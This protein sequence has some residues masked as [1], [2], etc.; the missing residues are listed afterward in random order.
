MPTT[1]NDIAEMMGIGNYFAFNKTL[2]KNIGLEEAI[3][4]GDL[5][6]RYSYY[7]NKG[8]LEND[9]FY[10][11]VETLKEDTTLS[12]YQQRKCFNNLKS[13]GLIDTH[14]KGLPAK[15]YIELHS[16]AILDMLRRG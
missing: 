12:D 15:R 2:A 7:F 3:I 1:I 6:N 13:L 14:I 8:L 11:T 16:D 10:C 5:I 4:L 9:M